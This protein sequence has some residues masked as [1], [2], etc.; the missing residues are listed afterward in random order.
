MVSEGS[1]FRR[2]GYVDPVTGRQYGRACPRRA[3]GS[4]RGRDRSVDCARLE[5]R[6]AGAFTMAHD[7]LLPMRTTST[8]NRGAPYR[9]I[10]CYAIAWLAVLTFV[11]VS[12]VAQGMAFGDLGSLAGNC[13]TLIYLLPSLA[14]PVWAYRRGAG[15]LFIAAAGLLE[16]GALTAVAPGRRGVPTRPALR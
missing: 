15:S 11:L 5:L 10:L 6:A 14:A 16:A 9:A 12:G 2:C 4:R 7:G 1:V 8:N 13:G 3:V